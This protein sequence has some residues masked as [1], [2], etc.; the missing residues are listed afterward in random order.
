MTT[1]LD[2]VETQQTRPERPRANWLDVLTFVSYGSALLT[3][4]VWTT[5]AL[6][7]AFHS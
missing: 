6:L 5:V 3:S 2:T 1:G 4:A 7:Q